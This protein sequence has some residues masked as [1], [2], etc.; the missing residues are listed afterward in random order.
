M[1]D[2]CE[3]CR[4]NPCLWNNYVDEVSAT[5]EWLEQ[6]IE[7]GVLQRVGPRNTVRRF[8]YRQVTLLHYG[9][10]GQGNRVRLPACFVEGIHDLYPD[11]NGNYMGHRDA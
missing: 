2:W 11:V 5:A 3:F 6:Q 8:C 1:S 7:L 9:Y 10:L 4:S